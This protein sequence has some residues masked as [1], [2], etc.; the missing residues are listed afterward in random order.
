MSNNQDLLFKFK[1]FLLKYV[2]CFFLLTVEMCVIA[3]ILSVYF[4][5]KI[6]HFTYISICSRASI[7]V[8]IVLPFASEKRVDY[9]IFSNTH[10]VKHLEFLYVSLYKRLSRLP[11]RM[12]NMIIYA[13]V[14]IWLRKLDLLI[15]A[16]NRYH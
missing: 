13:F 15:T 8:Y 7:S 2:E 3:I 14:V 5:A 6:S 12:S 16:D 4:C 1:R 9:L 10:T 11:M